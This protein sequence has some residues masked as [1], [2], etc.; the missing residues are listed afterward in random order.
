[1]TIT[2]KESESILEKA[3]DQAPKYVV[4]NITSLRD[5]LTGLAKE[6]AEQITNLLRQKAELDLIRLRWEGDEVRRETDPVLKMLPSM[7]DAIRV[8]HDTME[9]I[10]LDI[11][12]LKEVY[13]DLRQFLPNWSS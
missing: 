1:M 4:A 5:T 6:N 10:Q 13:V 9:T 8:T 3:G 11:D 7:K 12:A 2:L